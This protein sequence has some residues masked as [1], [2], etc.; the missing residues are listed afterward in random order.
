MAHREFV[1]EMGTPWEAWD[2][3]PTLAEIR[4]APAM[5]RMFSEGWLVFESEADR[6]RVTPIPPEWCSA[7]DVSLRELLGTATPVAA[8]RRQ[9]R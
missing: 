1:D 2:V 7:S 5:H 4:R 6:R 3:H 8:T 9:T